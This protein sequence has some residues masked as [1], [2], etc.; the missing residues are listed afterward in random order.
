M[1]FVFLHSLPIFNNGCFCFC[2]RDTFITR[3]Y[4]RSYA[5]HTHALCIFTTYTPP[6]LVKRLPAFCPLF[7]IFA[8]HAF[9]MHFTAALHF[10]IYFSYFA[11]P[12]PLR[13]DKDGHL[14]G[15]CAVLAGGSRMGGWL[16]PPA[17]TTPHTPHTHTAYLCPS[18]PSLDHFPSSCPHPSHQHPHHCAL[19]WH[20][21]PPF[22]F[23]ALFQGSLLCCHV[24]VLPCVFFPCV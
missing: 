12:F 19:P 9:Y 7:T 14:P 10:Y 17:T 15:M 6:P 1:S 3:I 2:A 11:H 8:P 5:R 21:S 20:S 23:V 24:C 18:Q 4:A 16:V 22:C 13:T